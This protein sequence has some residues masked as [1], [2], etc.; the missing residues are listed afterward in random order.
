MY[1]D[2][3]ALKDLPFRRTPDPRFFYRST[4]HEEALERL[5]FAVDE[6]ESALLTGD[7]GT[8]KTVLARTLI[9]ALDPSRYR[10]ALIVNPIMTPVQ[11]LRAI[12]MELGEATVM[13][14]KHDLLEHIGDCLLSLERQGLY[15]IVIIDEAH[16]IPSKQVFDEIRL[17]TN[18]QRDDGN[19]ISFIFIG[20]PELLARIRRKAYAALRQRI[21]ISYHIFPFTHDDLA[22]YLQ[23][24]IGVA[25]G[26]NKLFTDA[27]IEAILKKTGGVPRLINGLAH[28]SLLNAYAADL[29][30]A[31][32]AEVEEAAADFMSLQLEN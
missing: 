23:H 30:S 28:F 14:S 2:H 15:P 31:D 25:G 27:A 16:L 26:T 8:G 13:R 12:A 22:A 18:L 17:I 20:Q 4:V 5:L 7:I 10:V 21:G 32:A 3:F 1:L 24:R 29:A 6:Q 19:R 9:D 11:F